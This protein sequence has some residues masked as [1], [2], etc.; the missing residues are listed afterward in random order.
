MHRRRIRWRAKAQ[1]VSAKVPV[2]MFDPLRQG[3]VID[4]LWAPIIA[5]YVPTQDAGM[6]GACL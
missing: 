2:P 6:S 1:D 3:I 4:H 5:F